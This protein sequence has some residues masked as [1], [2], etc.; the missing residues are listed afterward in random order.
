MNMSKL[1]DLIKDL[2]PDG[3]E[4]KYIWEVTVWDKKFKGVGEEK[5]RRSNNVCF[6][7]WWLRGGR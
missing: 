1:N 3:V 4:Y 7:L 2:C 5:R 6:K